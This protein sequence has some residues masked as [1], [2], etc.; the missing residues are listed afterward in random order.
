MRCTE[1]PLEITDAQI[2]YASGRDVPTTIT[3]K[4]AMSTTDHFAHATSADAFTPT[5]AL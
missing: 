5:L 3:Q 2:I 4:I 1:S